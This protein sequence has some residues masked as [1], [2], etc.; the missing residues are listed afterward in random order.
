VQS[1][2][3]F[4]RQYPWGVR[5]K[6]CVSLRWLSGA[7]AKFK[8]AGRLHFGNL[9]ILSPG[10]AY[11]VITC[12][13]PVS[14]VTRLFQIMLRHERQWH[15]VA[16]PFCKALTRVNR[17]FVICCVIKHFSASNVWCNSISDSITMNRR[18]FCILKW[19][20]SCDMTKRWRFLN[21]KKINVKKVLNELKY[22]NK[23]YA[24]QVP[25]YVP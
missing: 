13:A 1:V 3:H 21:L 23:I 10:L 17:I 11:E 9:G 7:S 16:I 24:V 25:M 4:Y 18:R 22:L 2:P 5:D 19:R 6:A 15:N 8:A 14:Y 20:T 12:K